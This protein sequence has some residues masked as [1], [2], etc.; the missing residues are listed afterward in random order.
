MAK[1]NTNVAVDLQRTFFNRVFSW[2]TLGLLATGVTSMY[3]A[4]SPALRNF[5]LGNTILF[6]GL[7]LLELFAVG[8][9]AAKIN[10]MSEQQASLLFIGYSI[11]NGITLS[12]I[13]LMYTGA[14]IA[15]AFFV[16]AGTFATMTVYGYTTKSDL[17]EM[18]KLMFMGLIGIIIASIINVF[19]KS[20]AMDYIIS[21]V[22]VAVFIGLT[23]WDVQKLKLLSENA[24][25]EEHNNLAIYG[26]LTLYM[27][28]INLFIFM[29]RILGNRSRDY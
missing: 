1:P 8:F 18:G 7:I 26:A 22:G 11:L 5:F 10:S 6:F 13:F 3:V 19:L 23:A 28:F 9:L 16:T 17:S 12:G 25:A 20:S 24:S 14:S 15:L 27:D 2:M 29:L 4:S 21:Y